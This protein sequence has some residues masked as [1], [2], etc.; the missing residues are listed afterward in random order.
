M[1]QLPGALIGFGSRG[2]IYNIGGGSESPPEPTVDANGLPVGGVHPAWNELLSVLPQESH[3]QAIPVLKKWSQGVDSGFQKVHQ[4]YAPFKSYIDQGIDPEVIN[5]GMN[6]YNQVETNPTALF[7]ALAEALGYE[8]SD[9]EGN[10]NEPG[11]EE[12]EGVELPPQV[13]AQLAELMERDETIAQFIMQQQEEAQISGEEQILEEEIADL[14]QK[15]KDEKGYDFDDLW[16]LS[17]YEGGDD[18][19]E[20]AVQEFYTA[21]DTVMGNQNRP[22][23]PVLLGSGGSLPSGGKKPGSMTGEE[24]RAHVQG[25]LQAMNQNR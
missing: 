16:V 3:E 15:Y 23:P 11:E 9:L 22:K 21:M 20:T 18:D 1:Y 12:G 17:R 19:L 24:T 5:Y 10:P 13:Q 8:V 4:Q 14:H 6:L 25:I 2:P 7:S